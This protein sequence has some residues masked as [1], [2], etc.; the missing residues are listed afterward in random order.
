[1]YTWTK[2]YLKTSTVFCGAYTFCFLQ[3][4]IWLFTLTSHF[5]WVKE[6]AVFG[7]NPEKWTFPICVWFSL[8]TAVFTW[9]IS[10][11]IGNFTLLEETICVR[12][13][14]R[15]LQWVW[16]GRKEPFLCNNWLALFLEEVSLE[17][18]LAPWINFHL[19]LWGITM[20]REVRRM[21]L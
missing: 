11:Q 8:C 16:A 10:C 5:F 6:E 19:L 7:K 3:Q 15:C 18:Q 9:N 12:F 4:N 20:I 21:W 1:M 13:F 2:E 14:F 17:T